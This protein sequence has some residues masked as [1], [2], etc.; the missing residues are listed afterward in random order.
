MKINKSDYVARISTASHLQ[1][2][3]ISFEIIIDYINNSKIYINTNNKNFDFNIRKARQFLAD[4]KLSLNT[5]YEISNNLILIYNF[6]DQS[7]ISYL[8]N[9]DIEIADDCIKILKNLLEGFSGI[10]DLEEDKS[11][12]MENTHQIYAGLTYNKK[13]GLEEFID[14]GENRGFKA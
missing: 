14:N 7:L 4:L 13:G 12:I 1:L 5:D 8:F 9:E 3:I 6:L 11:S 2:V 10:E